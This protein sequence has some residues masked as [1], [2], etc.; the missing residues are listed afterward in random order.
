MHAVD[1]PVDAGA[2][3]VLRL[4]V[5]DRTMTPV[6][7]EGP[8]G[9]APRQSRQIREPAKVAAPEGREQADSGYEDQGRKCRMHSRQ[10][11]QR[12]P[13]EDRR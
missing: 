3:P 8:E 9:V 7:T 12:L 10:P 2:E 1:H 4:E 6:L 5:K 11:I 13:P